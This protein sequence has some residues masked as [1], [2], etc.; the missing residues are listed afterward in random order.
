MESNQ[1]DIRDQ[2]S[3]RDLHYA[4]HGKKISSEVD[5]V[6][7]QL[8]SES[9]LSD[10]TR[11]GR[12]TVN[13]SCSTSRECKRVH[14]S[15]DQETDNKRCRTLM[16]DDDDVQV[17]EKIVKDT[18]K[19]PKMESQPTNG[20]KELVDVIDVDSVPSPCPSHSKDYSEN[21]HCTVC[22][23]ALSP[24]DVRRHPLLEVI[25]CRAC[26]CFMKERLHHKVRSSSNLPQF[27]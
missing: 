11:E 15:V 3:E 2:S 20:V 25:S 23:K 1:K 13:G 14:S 7:T 12:Y 6:S 21:F 9:V 10:D 8:L 18:S 24:P 17:L 26:Y 5:G 16:S 19:Q 4:Q 22:C 27:I